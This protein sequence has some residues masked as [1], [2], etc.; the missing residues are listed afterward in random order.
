MS[1]QGYVQEYLNNLRTY[2]SKT[3]NEHTHRTDLEILFVA[4]CSEVNERIKPRQEIKD[5][6]PKLGVPDFSFIHQ[7]NLGTIGLVE[8][9]KVGTNLTPIIHSDQI[10]K[11]RKRCENIII[12]N[13]LDFILLKDGA[14]FNRFTLR[15][16]NRINDDFDINAIPVAEIETLFQVFLSE[17]PRDIATTRELAEQLALRCHDLREFL[18]QN[19]TKHKKDKVKTHLV[20]LYDAFQQYVDSELGEEDFADAFSQTLGY[21]LFIA[22]L[23]NDTTNPIDLYNIQK[24]IPSNFALIRDLANF[25]TELEKDEYLGIRHRVE[26]ILGMMNHLS[27]NDIIN[28]LAGRQQ[29]DLGERDPMIARDP[30]IY[31]Y[32]HFLHE[33]DADKKRERGV[34][35]TP[36]SVVHFI[37]RTVNDI[38]VDQFGI[39]HGLADHNDVQVLDFATGTGTFLH[40]AFQQILD[41]PHVQASH[42]LRE[43]LVRDHFLKNFYGFEYLIAPYTIAHLKL[44][45]FL[46]D[47]QLHSNPELNIL[48]TNTLDNIGGKAMQADLPFVQRLQQESKKARKVKQM[49][50]RVIMGNPPYAGASKNKGDFDEVVKD[51]YAP[52]GETKMNWD[53]YE[54]FICFAHQ[55]MKA[56]DRGVIGIITNN[57]FLNAITKRQMRNSLMRDFDAI[58]ILNLHGNSNIGEIAPDGRPDKNVFDI[59][60]GVAITF[61]IRKNGGNDHCDLYYAA[62]QSS[63]KKD[64]WRRVAEAD[65]TIFEKLDVAAFN[66]GF[67][68]T[69]WQNRFDEDISL[70]VPSNDNIG[71]QI[72]SYG[73]FWGVTDIFV[74]MNSGIQTKKDEIAIQYEHAEINSIIKD[75]KNLT[76]CELTSKYKTNDGV[77]TW[78]KARLSLAEHD[79]AKER[80]IKI[81]YRPFDNRVTFFNDR[82]SGFLARPRFDIMRHMLDGDNIAIMTCRLLSTNEWQ[83]I[84]ATNQISESA[85]VSINSREFG[86]H[87]PLYLKPKDA[88]LLAETEARENF[89]PS[90]RKW[91]DNKYGTAFTPEQIMGYI[92]AVL[93]SPTYRTRYVELLKL[94]YPRIPFVDDRVKF[95]A[96][97]ALGWDLI[98]THLMKTTPSEIAVSL[99]GKGDSKV[100]KVEYHDQSKRL[101]INE[102]QYF[103][104]VPPDAWTFKIGGYDVLDKYLKERKKA[105]R[106]L[107]LD[108]ITH[109]PKVVNILSWTHKQMQKIDEIFSCP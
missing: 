48:L 47:K 79:Y 22:K 43:Q 78:N 105:A 88:D 21:S 41:M 96:I 39:A 51:S 42:A 26:E 64:K 49:P 63:N 76:D 31:F 109:I 102:Q 8:V 35:Y 67:G 4:I 50:V 94:D 15:S 30:F 19:I 37:V 33:Y 66:K 18:T 95:E 101:S 58:Y 17:A 74:E 69:R 72:A 84:F 80:I 6:K 56:I 81:A 3:D 29:L 34:Y 2:N 103:D 52:K 24:F 27:L 9:K 25:L 55:K 10:K 11:Y 106:P 98:Q 97:S 85:F 86:Y 70:F 13:Y 87:I 44:A 104:N 28:E 89:K 73:D 1:I 71:A 14:E 7:D 20:N 40:E 93:H 54:K 5:S 61:F 46:R 59:K 45:Q 91:I 75:I 99:K 60:A 100:T 23:N 38:L 57:N 16:K 107:T 62:I 92:Y 53:D 77:W 68:A 108:E 65:L 90:F 36:P 82:S 83:H 12:T 32:E